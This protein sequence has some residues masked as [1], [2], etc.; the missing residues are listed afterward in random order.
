MIEFFHLFSVVSFNSYSICIFST[1]NVGA[2]C[3]LFAL[4]VHFTLSLLS[5]VCTALNEYVPSSLGLATRSGNSINSLG[6]MPLSFA[7]QVIFVIL[8]FCLYLNYIYILLQVEYLT[9]V[10]LLEYLIRL[11]QYDLLFN[12]H[13]NIHFFVRSRFNCFWIYRHMCISIFK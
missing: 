1:S 4:P 8:P 3:S 6:P 5:Y 9:L 12:W 2:G 7:F 11:F 10:L 13:S